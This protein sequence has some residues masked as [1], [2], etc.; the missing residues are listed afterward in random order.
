MELKPFTFDA[1]KGEY[2]EDREFKKIYDS[3]GT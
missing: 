2:D 3:L 1:Y